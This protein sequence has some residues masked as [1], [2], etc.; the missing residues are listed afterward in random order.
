MRK[1]SCP[2]GLLLL[3][4]IVLN[5]PIQSFAA[6]GETPGPVSQAW[7][8]RIN[9]PPN[10]YLHAAGMD[11]GPSGD[12]FLVS[13]ARSSDWA[14][15][16]PDILITRRNPSGALVWEK[17]YE[18][19]G[20]SSENEMAVGLVAIGS[21]I[22]VVGSISSLTGSLG[23][24]FLTL[25][26]RD[27]GELEW[28]A[29]YDDPGHLNNMAAAVTV[30]GLGNVLV[31]GDSNSTNGTV[32]ILV[33]K[34]GPTGN[35]L[36]TFAYDSPDQGYD[37][38]VGIR[39]DPAGNIYV[40]GTSTRSSDVYSVVAFKLDSD[41]HQLW[42][43]RETSGNPQGVTA[44]SLDVDAAGNVAVLGEERSY[45]VTWKYDALGNRQWKSR[46][47][48][49]EPASLYA[50][51]IRFDASGDIITAAN[52]YGSGV[53][54]A[55][56]V[57][58]AAGDGRQI[59]A[60]R[61]ADP[62][63][64]AHLNALGVD[65][66]GNSYLTVSPASDVVTVKV[67][68][69]GAQLWAV[70]FNSQGFYSD[71]GEFLKVAASGDI[72]VAGR[73]TQFADS[74]V[75]LVK[76]TQQPVG[77]VATAVVTPAFQV[78]D[79]G[80]HVVF[81]AETSGPEPIYY[82]WRLN[83]RPIPGATNV[84]LELANVSASHRGDYSVIISNP[85]GAT[86]SPE[87]RLSVRTPPEVAITPTETVAYVGTDAAFLAT[88]AGNDFTTLQWRYNGANIPGA[89]NE[90]FRI[91]TLSAAD[92]G[93]Y[94][95][96]VSTL[97]GITTSSAAGLRIS[98]AVKLVGT[99]PHRSSGST[100]DYAPQ[101]QVLPAGEF[102]IAAR[103]NHVMGSSIVLYKHAADGGLAWTS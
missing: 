56:L 62:A 102:L 68:P 3:V 61:V 96:M 88:V 76:Y 11:V 5:A 18:S 60:T 92:S 46:Y 74:F 32:D 72:L 55:L 4:A 29:R 2:S 95:V 6:T 20:S 57:K 35:L 8:V 13:N 41:G 77:S 36:W 75:S 14:N 97:G 33:L 7:A 16:D 58:Y 31:V 81:T 45:S 17:R 79:P 28:A 89:T 90:I 73:S 64:T 22:Y 10:S 48:A 99:T 54:D 78:V 12:V 52:L 38:A 21:A 80:T 44:R 26:Y 91:P 47:R 70:T 100:W 50:V 67:S 34:Y 39:T 94:D 93:A 101:L 15:Y 84:T 40:A 82:Q 71:Y 69:G 23:P 83:G 66:D 63:G 51:N 42:T 53:N 37:S 85:A 9:P 24:D 103:S 1:I 27:T 25:K 30:D 87:S 49:E 19:S 98:S 86:V 59:W 43:A 65:G